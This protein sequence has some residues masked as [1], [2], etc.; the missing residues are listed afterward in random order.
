MDQN[1]KSGTV[2]LC[3]SSGRLGS[4][5]LKESQNYPYPFQVYAP[6]RSELLEKIT[7]QKDSYWLLDVTLPE[8]TESLV[9]FFHQNPLQKKILKGMIIGST[10]H[11][12]L[13]LQKI[14]KLSEDLPIIVV[15]N[16]SLG[17]MALQEILK[18]SID[19][20]FKVI[21]LLKSLGFLSSLVEIHH[22]HKKDKPS[23]TAKSLAHAAQISSKDIVSLR[24]GEVVGDHKLIY[25][26]EGEEL[27]FQH[28]AH[29]RNIFAKG[30]LKL[31]ERAMEQEFKPGIYESKDVFLKNI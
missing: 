24:E 13:L 18:A 5:I 4:L 27:F 3:G 14:Q 20:D 15:S 30:A 7:Q 8:G 25:S 23:G 17:V 12:D 22:I 6:S 19:K 29:D 10:G 31:L 9:D 16:F 28:I 11:S 1:Q 21:D 26:R 2:I